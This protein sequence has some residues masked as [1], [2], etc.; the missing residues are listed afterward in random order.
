[1]GALTVAWVDVPF[2]WALLEAQMVL[3]STSDETSHKEDTKKWFSRMT[4]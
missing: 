4:G 2:P 1:M 3:K